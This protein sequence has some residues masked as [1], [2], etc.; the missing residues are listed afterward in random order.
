[1]RKKSRRNAALRYSL[2]FGNLLILAI[3]AL[4]VVYASGSSGSANA[5][6][7]S[8]S[9]SAELTSAV[10]PL[11]QVSAANIAASVASM[12]NLPEATAVR[13]QADSVKAQLAISSSENTVAA[14][15]QVIATA[16]RSRKDIKTYKVKKGDTLAS[17]SSKFGI[18][19]N[20]IKWSNSL[21]SGH[22]SKGQK[23]LIPP[24]SGIVYK[25]KKGDTADSL[26]SRFSANADQIR[27]FNDAEISG[28]KSGERIVIPGGSPYTPAPKPAPL[29][30]YG[31]YGSFS[32][33]YGSNGYDFGN[34]TWYVASQIAVPGN[35][36]NAATWAYYARL[37]GWHVS[38]TPSVG[39]IAQ[40]S[41]MAGGL[42]HVA[43]VRK[44]SGNRVYI[45]DMNDYADGG[46]F[47]R[48]GGGWVSASTFPNYITR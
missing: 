25:I 32:P 41:Y 30:T 46:G 23:L 11:D 48:V 34:C 38:H 4:V 10:S 22:L 13:N 17:L 5:G 2:I 29:P 33:A 24:V 36:G 39:A 1:M 9:A 27:S 15:T 47:D 37:S 26:A 28:L 45:N 8:S 35:W 3:I 19:S 14:K 7:A 43:I 18:T 40:N 12:T 20:S 16:F 21:K 44:V 31:V 42:G 6:Q